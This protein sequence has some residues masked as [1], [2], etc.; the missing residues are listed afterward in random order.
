G[1]FGSGITVSDRS[2]R[3][4]LGGNFLSA[5]GLDRPG[6]VRLL[7]DGRPDP[8]WNPGPALGIGPTNA[9]D[10]ELLAGLP[11]TPPTNFMTARPSWLALGSND[12]VVVGI[13]Y[14]APRG[15]PD[16]RIAVISE[17]GDVVS[18][19]SDEPLSGL[20]SRC[21]QPDGRILIADQN[22]TTWRG[23]PV[24]TLIRIEADGSLDTSFQVALEP[25]GASVSAMTLDNQGRL[26]ISG[27]FTAVNGVARPGLARLF[28]YDPTPAAPQL[29]ATVTRPRI[30]EGQM[31]FLAASVSGG[32][33]TGFQWFRNGVLIPDA[34]FSGLR[35]PVVIGTVPAGFQ[36]MAWNSLGT[37]TL[38]FGRTDV[39]IP[40]RRPGTPAPQWGDRLTNVFPITRL[41]PLPDG[42]LLFGAGTSGDGLV[43]MVGRLT[44]AGALDPTFGSG[45][46]VEGDGRV[47]DLI[48]Q[49]DGSVFV[50]GSFSSLGGAPAS[51]IAELSA[52]GQRS[53]RTFPELDVAS[54][55][56]LLALPDGQWILAGR[57][58]QVAGIPKFRLARLTSNF[59]LDPSFDAA[60]TF[61]PWQ[62]VDV[63]ALDRQGR[64][65]AGGSGL[66][67]EGSLTNPAPYGMVR[68]LPSGGLDPGFS[69]V[70][71]SVRSIFVESDGQIVTG[72]PLNRWDAT[73][74]LVT[75]FVGNPPLP[76]FGV[77]PDHRLVRLPDG[78]F[79]AP[80]E[81]MSL[82]RHAI[83]RWRP[84]GYVDDHFVS[85]FEGSDRP[86]RITACAALP[87]GSVLLGGSDGRVGLSIRRMYPDSDSQLEDPQWADGQLR[88]GL[89]T[90]PG[91]RYR[92]LSRDSLGSPATATGELIEGDGYLSPV[93]ASPSGGEGYLQVLREPGGE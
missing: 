51:G 73:G 2:G 21:V 7:G 56:T 8:G 54:V 1:D 75:P 58:S 66:A 79:V 46:I 23:V 55:T 19:F 74:Q 41:L 6:L 25:P 63:L 83:R 34:V 40:S 78:S 50:V 28:A 81:G 3:L 57:F 82:G 30:A 59:A 17:Q 77:E 85:P 9:A 42:R 37:N 92:V 64:L 22:L 15:S 27:S 67:S 52:S 18:V 90:Q 88:A 36:L 43:P 93:S 89:Y 39:G 32:P 45:G 84:D 14:V 72:M 61:Q 29:A 24:G 53:P 5:G 65:L 62:V 4:I 69:R 16:R 68:L 86:N 76:E 10:P 11:F 80:I 33:A 12:S 13:E 35:L 60:A 20:T 26:W 47:E 31:L 48:P 71:A 87:D 70:P 49:P 91:R 44:A 38:D